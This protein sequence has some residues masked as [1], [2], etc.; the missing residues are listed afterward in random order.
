MGPNLDEV[1][2]DAKQVLDAIANGGLGSGTMPAGILDGQQAQEV[3]GFVA[4][5]AGKEDQDE[6]RRRTWI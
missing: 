1:K 4:S 2:P 3:A 6:R 5:S